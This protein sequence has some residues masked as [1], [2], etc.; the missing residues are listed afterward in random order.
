MKRLAFLPFVFLFNYGMTFGQSPNVSGKATFTYETN[1]QMI[2]V[3]LQTTD[4]NLSIIVTKLNQM[5]KENEKLNGKNM[6]LELATT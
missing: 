4:N 6:N 2:P 5:I 3:A 1:K